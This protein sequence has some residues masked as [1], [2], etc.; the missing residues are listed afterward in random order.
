M[1]STRKPST[2]LALAE[3]QA[4]DEHSRRLAELRELQPLLAR[5][6]ELQ[7]RLA[8]HGLAIH[9]NDI[10]LGWYHPNGNYRQRRKLVRLFDLS[11]SRHAQAQR[12]LDALAELGFRELRRSGSLYPTAVLQ[13]GHLLLEVDVPAPSD[14]GAA[15]A[16]V[17]L[18]LVADSTVSGAAA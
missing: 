1:T 18:Q 11:F 12:R 10:H 3:Q 16:K 14:I 8:Q 6:D 13:R 2:L 7:P 4:N 9:P 15:T 17:Q 5:L